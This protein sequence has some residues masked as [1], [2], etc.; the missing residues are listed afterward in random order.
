MPLTMPDRSAPGHPTFGGRSVAGWSRVPAGSAHGVVELAPDRGRVPLERRPALEPGR[1]PR[2]RPAE[3]GQAGSVPPGSSRGCR[4]GPIGRPDSRRGGPRGARSPPR[5]P[6]AIVAPPPHGGRMRKPRTRVVVR[7]GDDAGRRRRSE[8]R[9]QVRAV[10]AGRRAIERDHRLEV[11]RAEGPD[12]VARRSTAPRPG[13]SSV[14][15]RVW[16]AKPRRSYS[17]RPSWVATRTSVE[18]AGRLGQVDRRLGQASTQALAAPRGR[19]P[20][21]ADPGDRAVDRRHARSRRPRRRPRRRASRSAGCATANSNQPRRSPQ[22]SA[23]I[24]ATVGSMSAAVMGRRRGVGMARLS[25]GAWPPS[26]APMSST[27][28]TSPGSA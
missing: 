25:S 18:A 12:R 28:P 10:L 27:S 14:W 17:G 13:A 5:R 8:C 3:L 19:D 6:A 2:R 9:Q 24:A 20:D 23:R 1:G 16:T 21:R 11:V 22:S 15:Y 7:P 26:R 4:S